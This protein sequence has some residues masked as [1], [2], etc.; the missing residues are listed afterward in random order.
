MENDTFNLEAIDKPRVSEIFPSLTK[1]VDENLTDFVAQICASETIVQEKLA[2]VYSLRGN[3]GEF[4]TN[5]VPLKA[6]YLP[7]FSRL[8]PPDYHNI[9][10]ILER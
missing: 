7:Y 3:L 4:G 1:A 10:R 2:F 8:G 5:K 9:C 6:H